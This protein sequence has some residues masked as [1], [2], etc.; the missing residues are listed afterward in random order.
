M[1][2]I[3]GGAHIQIFM[4]KDHKNNPFPNKLWRSSITYSY[5]PPFQF[6]SL[7]TATSNSFLLQIKFARR[8]YLLKE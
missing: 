2:A 8:F 6:L 5:A 1:P 7:Y 3:T 4:F